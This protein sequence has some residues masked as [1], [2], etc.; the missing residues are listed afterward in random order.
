MRDLGV[1]PTPGV[2]HLSA[3]EGLPAAMISASHNPFADNGIKLFS[4]GGLKLSD[5]TEDRDIEAPLAGA[6][7]ERT[8]FPVPSMAGRS[9]GAA[10]GDAPH[11]RRRC[12]RSSYT[13]STDAYVGTR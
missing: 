2:A 5:D 3:R 11:R 10:V 8:A 6:L 12:R 13:G 7:R 9:T 4:P 1:L